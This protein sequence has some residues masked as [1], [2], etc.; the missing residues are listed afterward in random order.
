MLQQTAPLTAAL[1]YIDAHLDD[2]LDRLF[3]L[4]RVPSI[5]T[6]PAF[7][8]E[9]RRAAT[10]LADELSALGFAAR[11]ADTAGHPIVV[12]HHPGTGPHVLFYGHYDVQ[13]AEPL[14]LWRSD[15]FV[16]RIETR[17]NG[18]RMIFGRGAS[19]DKGQLRTFIEACRAW[20]ASAGSLP[21]SVSLI[22]EGE[23]ECGSTNFAPFLRE[24]HAE[25]HADL[26]LACDTSMWDAETPALTMSLRGLVTGEVH[27]KA[28]SCD[29]HSGLYG[30]AAR[31]PLATMAA[32]LAGMHDA[33]GRVTLAG[34]YDGVPEV[35]EETRSAWAA[36]DFDADAFLGAVGLSTPAGETGYSVMEQIWARPTFEINGIAG[37][38]TG[39]GFKTV[40]PSAVTAKVSFRLVGRQDPDRIW[41]NFEQYVRARLTPDC[42]VSFVQNPG[43][44]AISL[45]G[46]SPA[47]AAAVEALDAEWRRSTVLMAAGGSIPIANAIKHVLDMEV[48]M[49]GFALNDDNIHAPNEKYE[50]TSFH[51]GM[52]SWVRLLAGL[53]KA[54]VPVE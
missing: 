15:P 14:D 37:G 22:I 3:A 39:V 2:S 48:L 36:L 21:C 16:P 45:P 44:P 41:A 4:M 24:H 10:M 12:A 18:S 34:F 11:V 43:S 28:A 54:A 1:A 47:V 30:G 32:L 17:A 13:P 50:L 31:N 8:S 33:D 38:Y 19:D 27:L 26:A 6:D 9:C 35:P 51:K 49:V 52:R 46:G 40:V 20:K 5:S 23:E 7:A 29:L 42:A 53:G 25:L